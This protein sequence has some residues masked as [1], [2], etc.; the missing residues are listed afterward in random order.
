MG[1]NGFWMYTG[2]KMVKINYQL[3]VTE[4]K[5]IEISSIMRRNPVSQKG[6]PEFAT[7]DL[8]SEK[9]CV[10][11]DDFNHKVEKEYADEE[12][13]DIYLETGK[14]ADYFMVQTDSNEYTY[15]FQKNWL[16]YVKFP[17]YL[18]IY[19]LSV[20]FIWLIQHIREK[21]L[22]ERYELQN[23]LQNMEIKSLRMQMDPHFMFNTFNSMALLLKSGDREEALDAFMKFTRMVRLNFDFSDQFTRQLSDEI[24]IVRQYLELNKLRFK[25]RLEFSIQ[26]DPEVPQNMTDTQDDA[27]DP[28][29]EC[30]ETWF[31]KAGK[32]RDHTGHHCQGRRCTPGHY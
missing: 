16:W 3:K 21:Q 24:D 32:N 31:V 27:S 29:G 12:V 26:I 10:Y 25:E 7:S 20:L 23:Q 22:S 13:K 1:E 14:G 5:N 9:V 28:C 18:L 17:V 30:P 19:L 8:H 4:E 11:T 2:D 6:S 15:H